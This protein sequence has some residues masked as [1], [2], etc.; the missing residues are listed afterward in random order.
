MLRWMLARL[1][2]DLILLT[3][4]EVVVVEES[5][6]IVYCIDIET[7]LNRDLKREASFFMVKR[8]RI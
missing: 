1:A 4:L 6:L 7:F 8:Y 5:L 2:W 3:V